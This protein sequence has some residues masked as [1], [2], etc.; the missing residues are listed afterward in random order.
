MNAID[1][2]V[3][4]SMYVEAED[5]Y[6]DEAPDVVEVEIIPVADTGEYVYVCEECGNPLTEITYY[7]RYYCENCGLHY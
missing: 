3:F 7:N 5:E 6:L 2:M 4:S 1:A